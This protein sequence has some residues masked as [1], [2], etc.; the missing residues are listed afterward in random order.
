MAHELHIKRAGGIPLDKWKR[1]VGGVPGVRL[2]VGS[3]TVTNPGTGERVTV[4]GCDGD[5]AVLFEGEWIK[6][7]RF[8]GGRVS[9]KSV[10]LG[11]PANAVARAASA[12][13]EIL[14]ANII[15][16]DGERYS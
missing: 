7:F 4:D 15:G 16:D 2:D 13:A 11:D 3:V 12:L 6:V 9:F 10:D 1:A 14:S 5:A 8:S